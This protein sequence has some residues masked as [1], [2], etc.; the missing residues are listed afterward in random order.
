MFKKM[1]IT[2]TPL[3]LTVLLLFNCSLQ[4]SN[5]DVSSE[6]IKE[7]TPVSN[8]V[9]QGSRSA[10]SVNRIPSQEPPSTITGEKIPAASAPQFIII[11]YDDNQ[12]A[13]GMKNI[14]DVYKNLQ[15]PVGSGNPLT[16]DGTP[17]RASFYVTPAG[18]DLSSGE[19]WEVD[20]DTVKTWKD[21]YADGHEIGNHTWFHEHG[22]Q[23]SVARWKE[24]MT[25]T[26]DFIVN[27]LNIPRSKITG[28]RTP[29]LEYNPNTFIALKELG[30]EYDNSFEGGWRYWPSENGSTLYWPFTMD[31]GK[32]AGSE[33]KDFGTAPGLWQ[34]PT[35]CVFFETAGSVSRTTGFDY[36]LWFSKATTKQEFV[37]IL[38]FSLHQK[39]D[40][41]RS[42]MN[43]G[44]HTNYYSD[45]GLAEMKLYDPASAA[46]LKST[47]LERTAA[48]KE[49][50]EYALTLPDV[51]VVTTQ[52]ALDW[53][54][55]PVP[56]G[57]SF[58]EHVVTINSGANGVVTPSGV[59]KVVDGR[60]FLLSV[61]PDAGYKVDTFTV[62]SLPQTLTDNI[63]KILNVKSPKMVDVTFI[64]DDTIVLHTVTVTSGA[65]GSFKT[66]GSIVVE[67]G[68]DLI[69]DVIPADGYVVDTLVVDSLPVSTP[70]FPYTL[71]NIK[72]NMNISVTF[73]HVGA[74]YTMTY[75]WT[76][77]YEDEPVGTPSD[78]QVDLQT[79]KGDVI[80]TVS[81]PLAERISMEGSG[82]LPDGTLINLAN[83]FD[84]P[85]ARFFVVDPQIAPWGY[86]SQGGA[87]IP[88]KSIAVDPNIIPLNS[89][90]YIKELD[91]VKLPD[92]STH[93]G[94][95]KAVDTS[96]S[97]NGKWL[98]IFSGTYPNYQYMV[99][100]LNGLDKVSVTHSIGNVYTITPTLGINGGMWPDTPVDVP[101]GTN[102]GFTFYPDN[103]YEIDRVL[104]DNVPVNVINNIYTFE[105]VQ[106]AMSI[107][108]TFTRGDPV[109]TFNV[110]AVAG[111]GGSVSPSN[112][113][114][115]KGND[116]LLTITPQSGYEI[117]RA[118][119]NG[120]TISVTGNTY[121][122]SSIGEDKDFNVTFKE[123]IQTGLTAEYTVGTD[124]GT[125]F[126]AAIVITNGL[127]VDVESWEITLTY[128]GNQII[129]GWNG[130]YSQSGHVVTIINS[131]WNGTIPPGGT[132][133]LGMN[134]AYS[135]ENLDPVVVIK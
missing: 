103:G 99:S 133:S 66:E 15:N 115:D 98:D 134:G 83:G 84:W 76:Y 104:V 1:L 40:G 53:V 116:V 61:T 93:N 22:L 94:W 68:N 114:A 26:N 47:V 50:L 125:G 95:F 69:I 23:F 34:M 55:N 118:T 5:T 135:G 86:D 108:V 72:N 30:F 87:L 4:T 8:V 65:N 43:F 109:Q 132:L 113:T 119:L 88:W 111:T 82:F 63:Y 29:F 14:M 60:D 11:G 106:K 57:T 31:S 101:E 102:R 127:A 89:D 100:I 16:Y 64:K 80:A 58:V 73:K 70:I 52:Q 75:Y 20:S 92:N 28:F 44:G 42:P 45:D 17:A 9:I 12:F 49:F 21:A 105:N 81:K 3:I 25:K 27:N 2:I 41:N 124:W 131:S 96:H 126:G 97:F 38:K 10:T 6:V 117:D 78:P 59:N 56:L 107:E 120:S 121:T 39:Y 91:G 67:D 79:V 36:N 123:I 130:I 24:E 13:D 51:R 110:V 122:I 48:I 46:K 35:D 54:K 19:T 85:N 62:D 37:D 77:N 33:A 112:I 74:L 71:T 128:Q 32:P 90:V 18:R 7:S 129:S